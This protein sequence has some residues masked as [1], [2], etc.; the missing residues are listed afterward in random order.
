MKIESFQRTLIVAIQLQHRQ[1]M[2]KIVVLRQDLSM[3][4]CIIVH[5]QI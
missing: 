1:D 2:A 5:M 3:T 4:L